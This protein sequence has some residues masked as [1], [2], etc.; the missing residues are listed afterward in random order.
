MVLVRFLR[1]RTFWIDT[2][3]TLARTYKPDVKT[4]TWSPAELKAQLTAVL[5]T[6]LKSI[7]WSYAY[8]ITG[9]CFCWGC[10]DSWVCEEL[11]KKCWNR[12]P[13]GTMSSTTGVVFSAPLL[14]EG[15]PTVSYMLSPVSYMT[16]RCAQKY[17]HLSYLK[18]L[19][20]AGKSLSWC[21]QISRLVHLGRFVAEM[22]FVI[23][24]Y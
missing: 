9:M 15:L 10:Q 18:S 12:F 11:D 22:M 4:R 19:E 8:L 24:E 7:A 3:H 2:V 6:S 17:Q 13:S 5:S 1:S 23:I 21:T 16:V 14:S 20:H